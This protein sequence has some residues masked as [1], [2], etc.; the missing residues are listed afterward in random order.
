MPFIALGLMPELARALTERGY[1]EP[2]PVQAGVVPA[3]LAGR[4]IL[5]GAQTGT[6]K[7]AGFTLPMLQRLQAGAPQRAPRAL[8]LVPTRELATQVHESVLAYGKYLRLRSLVVFG[9]VG[10]HPQ[11]EGL[12][13]GTDILVAT[14]GRLLD[15]AQQRTVDLS[16]VE[17]LVLD[18]ADRMLD[19]GFIADIRRVIK[20]LPPQRQ[21]LMFSATYSDDIRR[22]AQS[23]LHHLAEVEVAR[24]NAAVDS[25]EQRV[26]RV[27]KDSKRALLSHLIRDEDWSQVLVFTRTKH[28]ANRLTKQLQQ[29]GIAAAAIHGNKSQS[30]RTQALAGFKNYSIR[31]LVATEVAS[32]GLDIK[33]LPYV[34]NYELPNV[35]EDYVH[36]IGRTGRAGASGIAVSLVSGDESGLLKD[37]EKLLRKQI[38]QVRLPEFPPAPPPRDHEEPRG[39]MRTMNGSRQENTAGRP[40]GDRVVNSPSRGGQ[41][42]HARSGA[43]H[44]LAR[45][46]SRGLSRSRG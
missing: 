44:R 31:A 13:R 45:G 10:I 16:H 40:V 9:G 42:G 6:G 4:D 30:A 21:N 27:E 1:V 12:R 38:P 32:R 39:G 19:M 20:L 22:L 37:I 46:R 24:R 15:H 2:T 11:I 8:I 25:V 18:E 14:P 34:V 36:R 26:Y 5:A 28:G 33:E 35:P 29:D 41:Q 43:N 3:I 17:I 7:T 23:L